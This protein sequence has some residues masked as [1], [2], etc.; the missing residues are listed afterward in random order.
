LI[1]AITPDMLEAGEGFRDPAED[2]FGTIPIG[3]IGRVNDDAEDQ[4]ECIDQ[5]VALAAVDF[6]AS[7]IATDPP[8]SVVFTD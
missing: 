5:Q 8:F 6:L 7:V 1:A 4:A 3:D 2:E